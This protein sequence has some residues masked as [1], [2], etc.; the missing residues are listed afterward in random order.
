M[1]KT[2]TKHPFAWLLALFAAMLIAPGMAFADPLMVATQADDDVVFAVYERDQIGVD[3]SGKALYGEPQAVKTF[4]QGQID[5]LKTSTD[6]LGYIMNGKGGASVL[7]TTDY[8]K[9]SD[10]LAAAGEEL[11]ESDAVSFVDGTEYGEPVK[12][13]SKWSASR[14]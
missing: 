1:S 14:V 11:G 6:K 4:T 3:A 2:M 8:A 13:Y 9:V 5:A 10:I 7:A 12:V